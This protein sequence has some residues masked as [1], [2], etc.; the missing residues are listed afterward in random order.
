MSS[1]RSGS[2]ALQPGINLSVV[3][4]ALSSAPLARTLPSGDQLV[5]LEVTVR[6]SDGRAESVPVTWFA[7]PDSCL[8]WEPGQEVVV[9]GRVRRRFYRHGGTTA[10][11]T[12]VVAHS[13][14]PARQRARVRKLLDNATEALAATP[15]APRGS[16]SGRPRRDRTP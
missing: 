5:C 16:S 10:S 9:V 4:G 13:V 15:G 12:E 14:V 6:P 7:A 8:S 11:R 3:A 2:D 1:T